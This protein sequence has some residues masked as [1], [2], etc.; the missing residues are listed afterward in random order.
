MSAGNFVSGKYQDDAGNIYFCRRQ[1]ETTSLTLNGQANTEPAG[2]VDQPIAA[3]LTGGLKRYG[4]RARQVRIR[5]TAAPPTGY[6]DD[7]ILTVPV[8]TLA[9]FNTMKAVRGATGTYLGSACE[10]VGAT[11]EVVK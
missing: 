7:D 3:R 5:F 4:V 10:L 11:G 1:P 8:F 9:A 6:S 2:D